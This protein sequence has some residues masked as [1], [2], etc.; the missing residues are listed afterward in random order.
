MKKCIVLRFPITR[1]FILKMFQKSAG[2][3]WASGMFSKATTNGKLENSAP[4]VLQSNA[5]EKRGAAT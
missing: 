5:Q 4:S 2:K 1:M 3:P